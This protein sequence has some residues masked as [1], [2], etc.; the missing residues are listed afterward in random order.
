MISSRAGGAS[1]I[2][3]LVGGVFCF[4]VGVVGLRHVSLEAKVSRGRAYGFVFGG[5]IVIMAAL[6]RGLS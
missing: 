6:L 1:N 3:L 5:L 4:V 2:E